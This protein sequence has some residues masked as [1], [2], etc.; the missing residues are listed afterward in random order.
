MLTLDDR[1]LLEAY[2]ARSSEE[3][4]STLVSRYLNLVYSAALRQV[5]NRQEAE[6]IT[7]AVFLVLARKAKSLGQGTVLSG[8]LYQ[9][10]RL[11][12]ANSLRREIRRQNREQQAYMQ[13]NLN[14]PEPD[15]WE[16]IGPLLEQAMAGLS[17]ADRNAIVLRYFENKPLKEVGAALGATDD[18]AKMRINR[19]LEK[20]RAFFLKR[21]VTLSAT[22]LGAAIS[23]HSIEA[24]PAGLSIAVV[25]AVCQ[26]SALTASTLTLAKGTLKLMAW[27]KLNIAAGVAAAAVIALQWGKIESQKVEFTSLQRQL[28]QAALQSDKQLAAIKDLETRDETM[29]RSL[30]NMVAQTTQSAARK[31]AAPVPAVVGNPP[32]VPSQGKTSG[33]VLANLLKDPDMM[34]AMVEQQAQLLKTEFAPLVKQ[35]NLKPEQG[36]AFYKLLT[37]NV[38]N[39]MLQ[40]L[41]MMEGA[42][43]PDAAIAAANAEKNMQDQMRLLLGDSGYSQ[44]QEFQATLSDRMIFEQMQASFTDD[45][46]TGDQQQRLLQIMINERKNPAN[47]MDPGTG[48][49][50]FP[51]ATRA[52][53]MEQALQI[54]DQINQQ[55]YQQAT[56]FL[57]PNQLQ[58]LANT[59]SN[60]LS[61]TRASLP[62]MQKMFGTESNAEPGGQ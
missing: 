43:D 31:P 23:A 25:A 12:A 29:A 20:L 37:D 38:T 61:L 22:G 18:A 58:T 34:K 2:A 7:Q 24:A 15:H 49:P 59:Q 51:A 26:G 13:S 46:L 55:V 10:A 35:L 28:Q 39:T 44:Y 60:L 5:G 57:T 42:K 6:E 62:M 40:S 53:Q 32:G 56:Q 21:G 17:E 19:A 27:T 14:E 33:S 8:W 47:G 45:P 4:F 41:A 48:K 54:Q 50:A 9:T 16:Q 52:A 1:Q 36:D 3:A 11:T 30:R